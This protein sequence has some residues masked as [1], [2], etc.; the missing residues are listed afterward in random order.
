M[1]RYN[2]CALVMYEIRKFGQYAVSFDI[3]V[4]LLGR[5]VGNNV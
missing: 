1:N 4:C 5:V 2:T 3:G